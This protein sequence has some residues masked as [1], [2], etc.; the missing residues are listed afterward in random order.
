MDPPASGADGWETLGTSALD[1]P[2]L[3]QELTLLHGRGA[4][5]VGLP[6]GSALP[7]RIILPNAQVRFMTFDADLG[8][9]AARA[10]LAA[11]T[12]YAQADLHFDIANAD[13]KIYV[14]AVASETL[15]EAEGFATHYG[16]TPIGHT[17]RSA[18]AAFPAPAHFPPLNT[19]EVI[20][21]AAAE[22]A[23]DQAEDDQP[24]PQGDGI[25][26]AAHEATSALGA[27]ADVATDAPLAI[28]E[29][30]GAAREP[31]AITPE[32]TEAETAAAAID[33]TDTPN[34]ARE[35]SGEAASPD[36]EV[37]DAP[38]DQ[39]EEALADV[40]APAEQVVAADVVADVILPPVLMPDDTEDAD[41]TEVDAPAIAVS[42]APAAEAA[43]ET[44]TDSPSAPLIAVRDDVVMPEPTVEV[45]SPIVPPSTPEDVAQ[46]EVVPIEVPAVVLPVETE[47][48]PPVIGPTPAVK[49]PNLI[50]PALTARSLRAEARA[51][52]D[53][54]APAPPPKPAQD[55]TAQLLENATQLAARITAFFGDRLKAPSQAAPQVQKKTPKAAAA[56]LP[57]AAKPDLLPDIPSAPTSAIATPAIERPTI[58]KPTVVAP[59]VTVPTAPMPAVAAPV[60]RAV[61]AKATPRPKIDPAV[62]VAPKA[63]ARPADTQ[64]TGKSASANPFPPLQ[65]K[66]VLSRRYMWVI[67]SVVLLVVM[68]IVALLT[69]AGRTISALFNPDAPE[70][71][72]A[73]VPDAAAQGAANAVAQAMQTAAPQPS[74]GEGPASSSP[75]ALADAEAFHDSTGV[76]IRSA[77]LGADPRQG[78][79]ALS[80]RNATTDAQLAALAAQLPQAPPPLTA[81]GALQDTPEA[82]AAPPAAGTRLPRDPRG[83]VLATPEG[84]PLPDGRRI[85]A[86]L[87]ATVPPLRPDDL[88]PA[89]VAPVEQTAP[90]ATEEEAQDT[91]EATTSDTATVAL[92]ETAR[93]EDTVA[94]VE[95]GPAIARPAPRPT[96]IE[97]TA[98]LA[99]NAPITPL[100]PDRPAA[101]TTAAAAA[102]AAA[103]QEAQ[104]AAAQAQAQATPASPG[105]V[106]GDVVAALNSIMQNAPDPV[107]QQQAAAAAR[108]AARTGNAAPTREE[109]AE[110][111]EIDIP[112]SPTGAVPGSVAQAATTA[113]AINTREINLIGV[114]GRQNDRRALVR[115]PNGRVEVVRVGDGLDGGQV[116]AIGDNIIN[117]VKRGRTYALQIAGGA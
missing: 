8:D 26:T 18:D 47:A 17:C 4:K 7:V 55:N 77:R 46:G 59:T 32:A 73:A 12:P 105:A 80:G 68:L 49:V 63:I 99:L 83:F 64:P 27:K 51:H 116:T 54:A 16:F 72:V 20:V 19:T 66:P 41:K 89:A 69:P 23:E 111:D 39:P 92:T 33:E 30:E 70:A 108:P 2:S 9:D 45:D 88:V 76:W 65:K 24:E 15:A 10:E 28:A 44:P 35:N 94:A 14:A 81:E 112:A 56:V 91:P 97:E 117:Y 31:Q 6:K 75:I 101:I 103:A 82:Q 50:S 100:P 57:V 79:M 40:E 109:A 74:T 61:Q 3:A 115:M 113:R 22:V 29:A 85:F 98:A 58:D 5:A 34:A 37:T 13:G 43:I 25:E 87:P 52:A 93:P 110:A 53:A 1:S 62:L 86:G 21:A 107:A 67:L 90:D 114:M 71:Q 102:T 104:A 42:V 106:G 95:P 60:K 38:D 48:A 78:E 36:P 11:A 84:T 96:E